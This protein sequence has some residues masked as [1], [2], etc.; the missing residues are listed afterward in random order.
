M[1][2]TELIE[3]VRDHGGEIVP[4]GEQIRVDLP[5]ELNH[6]IPALKEHKPEILEALKSECWW[7]SPSGERVTVFPSCPA[8]GSYALWREHPGEPYECLSC[9]A[10]GIPEGKARQQQ[11][12]AKE[13]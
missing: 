4:W 8:C 6:L 7:K 2:A 12:I 3:E 10:Q 11:I 1:T 13:N 9:C 5:G